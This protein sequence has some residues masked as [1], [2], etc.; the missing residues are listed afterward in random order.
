MNWS[1]RPFVRLVMFYIPGIL[2]GRNISGYQ[3]DT[4]PFLFFL[5]IFL[6]ISFG[7]VKWFISYKYKW[8]I[9]LALY[10]NVFLLGVFN[11][12]NCCNN[13]SAI[14]ESASSRVLTAEIVSDPVETNKSVKAVVEALDESIG[15]KF[16][17]LTYFEKT[18]QSQ[19]LVYGDRIA[20]ETKPEKYKNAGNPSEFDYAFYLA[21]RNIF[22]TTFVKQQQWN[23][24]GYSPSNKIFAFAKSLRNKLLIK[25]KSNTYFDNTYEVSAAILLGYDY[26]MDEET[27]QDFVRAGAMH[28][29]CVSGLHVGV[30][31]MVFSVLLNF[32]KVN[33]AG[34]M[35]RMVL[36]LAS[37][38]AYA[39]LTGMSPS[40]QRAATMLSF[41]I[42]GEASGRLRDNYN[43]LAASAFVMLLFNPALVFSVGFQLSYAAVLGIISVYRPVFNLLYFENVALKYLWSVLAVSIAA[44]LGT[45]PIATHY[46][47]Y[48]PTYFWVVNLFVIPF[49]FLVIVSGFAF[50]LVSWI[51]VLSTAFGWLTS[52]WVLV[53]SKGVAFVELLP[54]Y[55]VEDIYMPWIKL[56]TVYLIFITLFHLLFKSRFL[57]LKYVIFLV[58][59][60]MVFNTAVKYR[61]LLQ[62]EMVCYNVKNQS[63]VEFMDGGNSLL[64]AD[65]VFLANENVRD[66]IL[67]SNH[68]D[69]GIRKV[70]EF[71]YGCDSYFNSQNLLIDGCFIGFHN[72]RYLLLSTTDSVYCPDNIPQMHFDAVIVCGN[73][74]IDISKLCRYVSFDKII[75][76]SS[77]SDWKSR[78]LLEDCKDAG[79]G[80]FK[81]SSQGAYAEVFR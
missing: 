73:K 40:V 24:L 74:T 37:V 26:L 14:A 42:V 38:W 36:L 78:R 70:E 47:H 15:K 4:I 35:L 44:Q 32:L 43:T 65:S 76:S 3:F 16:K 68:I 67:K 20:L 6:L 18:T 71:E 1:V 9:G 64:V 30:I 10:S 49:S 53:L 52:L 48:F 17:I 5:L 55:G 2:L 11:S 45:F 62:S 8:L 33:Y 59:I 72:K 23:Y 54:F 57:L 27:E 12:Y 51:P 21:N 25:L 75:I 69:K 34:R 66:F 7:V 63:V 31:F 46:F 28:I 50:F 77:V 29:L 22:Y 81:L 61:N 60:L 80:S 79:I 58:L 41:F 13:G 19:N 56:L 39:L